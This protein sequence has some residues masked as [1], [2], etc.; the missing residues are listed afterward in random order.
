MRS[1][2]TDSLHARAISF[3]PNGKVRAGLSQT[4]RNI[5]V[6]DACDSDIATCSYGN[7]AHMLSS[8]LNKG[9]LII[10]YWSV[11]FHNLT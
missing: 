7:G 8:V 3:Q 2:C 9:E 1:F 4:A 10:G 11:Y 6:R 5:L